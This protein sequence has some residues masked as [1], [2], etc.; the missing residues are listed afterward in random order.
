MKAKL[1]PMTF[2]PTEELRLLLDKSVA[3]N[4][5]SLSVEII[6]RLAQSFKKGTK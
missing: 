2:R 4:G 5:N 1:A 3:K 6:H